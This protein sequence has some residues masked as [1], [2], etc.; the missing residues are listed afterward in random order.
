MRLGVL[1][2]RDECSGFVGFA[3]LRV[4]RAMQ[5]NQVF[6]AKPQTLCFGQMGCCQVQRFSHAVIFLLQVSWWETRRKNSAHAAA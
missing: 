6:V 1:G 4:E 5:S 2:F 3:G